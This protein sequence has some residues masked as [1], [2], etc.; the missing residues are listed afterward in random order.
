MTWA[1]H[2]GEIAAALTAACW[3]CTAIAFEAAGLRIGSLAVNFLRLVI[4]LALLCAYGW[5]LRG[6]PLPLDAPPQAW[7]W[8]TASSLAGLVIGDI[9][10]FRAFMVLGPRLSSLIMST[11]PVFTALLGWAGL[12]ETMTWTDIAGMTAVSIGIAWAVTARASAGRR[13]APDPTLGGIA[14]AFGGAIGQAAGLV[15]S[16]HGMGQYDAFAATQIRVIA[17]LACFVV[18][19]TALRWWP[20]VVAGVRD[21]LGLIYT[22]LGAVFGPF[23]GVSLSLY[24]VQHANAGVAASIMATTPILIIPIVIIRGE[25]VPWGGIVGA[26]VTVA[27]VVALFR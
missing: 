16:K 24:A 7:G 17:A 21:R 8:L 19:F 12:G 11:T 23:L 1:T 14:L 9:C 15:L 20:R 4:G 26:L 2:A 22:A 25:R 10:L 27:G 18:L 5:I 13:P 3:A 6:E